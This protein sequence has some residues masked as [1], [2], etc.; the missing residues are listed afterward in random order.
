MGHTLADQDCCLQFLKEQ[1]LIQTVQYLVHQGQAVSWN[2]PVIMATAHTAQEF[3]NTSLH[4]LMYSFNRGNVEGT[5]FK[6]VFHVYVCM[7]FSVCIGT[8]FVD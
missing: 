5:N 8:G 2:R 6:N 7:F 3:N 4:S 1:Q